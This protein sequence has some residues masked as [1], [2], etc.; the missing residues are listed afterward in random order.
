[1][2]AVLLPLSHSG[3][4]L[5]P[6]VFD[7][8]PEIRNLALSESDGVVLWRDPFLHIPNPANVRTYVE[9]A[10]KQLLAGKEE[11]YVVAARN[12][13]I[14]GTTRLQALNLKN[15]RVDIGSTWIHPNARGSNLNSVT[16][17]LLLQRAFEQMGMQ[18]VGFHAHPNNLRSRRALIGIGASFEGV[19]R[20][21][22]L[23]HGTNQDMCAYSLVSADWPVARVELLSRI[24]RLP[25]FGNETKE[26]DLDC[27]ERQLS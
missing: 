18:R 25:T 13:T 12:G 9:T 17:F 20:N 22:Q 4:S 21:F 26:R 2:I 1:M 27:F 16:K 11:P 5:Y 7:H 8:L 15:R 10:I 6:M 24:G 23:L 14:V 19:L 3:Y